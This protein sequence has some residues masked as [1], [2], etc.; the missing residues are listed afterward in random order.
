MLVAATAGGRRAHLCP[1][2]PAVLS[3]AA[4]EAAQ[5]AAVRAAAAFTGS[6][7][8]GAQDTFAI[9]FNW[10]PASLSRR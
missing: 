8:A 10:T 7:L 4:S 1:A 2:P 9:G 5:R 6:E 3:A